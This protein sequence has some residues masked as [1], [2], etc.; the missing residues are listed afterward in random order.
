MD[1]P[2]SIPFYRWLLNEENSVGLADLGQVA[3][4]VQGT[5]LRL[6]EIVKQREIIQNDPT[7]DAMEKT[8]KVSNKQL[9]SIESV[10]N[11][12]FQQIEALDLDGCTIADL[13]LDF[14]LPG[15]PN[16][17]LRRGGRDIQV[18]IQ[19]LHQYISLVTHWF[20]VEGV[21]RQ[22]EA[23][24]EGKTINTTNLY[25]TLITRL[26]QDSTRFSRCN[27]FAFSTQRSWRTSSAA[28][29]H[30]T[31][32]SGTSECWPTAAAL[33]TVSRKIRRPF[34]RSTTFSANTTVRS[35]DCS[36]SS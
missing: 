11:L 33:T 8:E 14:V 36:C 30:Q 26:L 25:M 9:S 23:F 12:L 32:R 15:Y 35:S 34:N 5:L 18:N 20:L 13:G 6:H 2:F 31:T 4:E 7:L 1:L 21:N 10:A 22:F 19:N 29:A 16:I 27:I 3:P 17:E 28:P 24:R